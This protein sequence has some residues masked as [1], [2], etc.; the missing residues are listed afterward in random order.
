MI[1]KSRAPG[2][3]GPSVLGV[4]Q[5]KIMR[6]NPRIGDCV[7]GLRGDTCSRGLQSGFCRDDPQEPSS[8]VASDSCCWGVVPTALFTPEAPSHGGRAGLRLAGVS[9]LSGSRRWLVPKV[10]VPRG[11]AF[12][13]S[14][15]LLFTPGAA[16]AFFFFPPQ[17]Q[18]L[19]AWELLFSDLPNFPDSGPV[20]PAASML[21]G[22]VSASWTK[23]GTDVSAWPSLF[24]QTQIAQMGQS[25]FS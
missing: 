5:T 2:L 17:N 1:P 6:V 14:C 19:F 18:L 15:P 13:L 21:P 25:V 11:L 4:L 3:P 22:R 10:G 12:L 7:L 20:E 9:H 24:R 16:L 8:R 23:R